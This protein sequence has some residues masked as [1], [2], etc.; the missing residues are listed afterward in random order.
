MYI[1]FRIHVGK[2]KYK[3]GLASMKIVLNMMKESSLLQKSYSLYI[4]NWYSYPDIC[5]KLYKL[6]TNVYGTVRIN[7]NVMPKASESIK[8]KCGEATILQSKNISGVKWKDEI[9]I[10]ML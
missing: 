2:D 3:K 4:D 1:N 6:K 9:D 5:N 7:R 10:F 8:L